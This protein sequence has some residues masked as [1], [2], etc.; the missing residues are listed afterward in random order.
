M[1]SV[2]SRGRAAWMGVCGAL[3]ALAV[4]WGTAGLMAADEIARQTTKQAEIKTA[5]GKTSMHYV[6]YL[7]SGY[8]NNVDQNYALVLF[9]HGAGERGTDLTKVL[10]H[11]P[12][13][14]AESKDFPCIIVSPQCA[15]GQRWEAA[16]LSQ[17]LNQVERELRVDPNR[18][19]V[20][21]LSMGG[22]GTWNLIAAEPNRFAAAAP[23]CGGGQPDTAEKIKHLPIWV[24]H[25]TDDKA[26][27]HSASEAMVK[28]LKEAGS[29]VRFTSYQGV[30]HD[31]WTATYNDPVFWEWLLS[32]E[33]K[34]K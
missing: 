30:G 15:E 31:S 21:G 5:D 24:F 34:S 1:K 27:P 33:R 32:Q 11:G 4:G 20:T 26:V 2:F 14:L 7:P 16:A 19:Y 29:N 13:K 22:Y 23:I 9:L 6:L 3:A 25:G 28:A 10:K 17:L 8:E 18:I 12:P